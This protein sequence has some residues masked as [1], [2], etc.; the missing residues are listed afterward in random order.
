MINFNFDVHNHISGTAKM[1]VAKFCM[2]VEYIKCQPWDD[3]LP[4]GQGHVTRFL[5]FGL[6]SYLWNR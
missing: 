4:R 5:H 6:Q 3:E 1:R 2:E